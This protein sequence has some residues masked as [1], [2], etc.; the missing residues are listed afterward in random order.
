MWDQA[1]FRIYR[2]RKL[3][4]KWNGIFALGV[5]IYTYSHSNK[6][7]P[8]ILVVENFCVNEMFQK[9]FSVEKIRH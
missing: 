3:L 8:A 1:D 7:L 9:Y 4:V 2:I 5:G 6:K